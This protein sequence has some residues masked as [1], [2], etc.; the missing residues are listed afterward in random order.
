MAVY[1]RDHKLLFIQAPRTGSSAVGKVLRE[2]LGGEWLPRRP[3]LDHNGMKVMSHQH[4]TLK[5]LVDHD[6]LKVKEIRNLI[7][8]TT[9]RNPYDSVVSLYVK[10]AK[11]LPRQ[12]SNSSSWIYRTTNRRR[13][14]EFAQG[15]SFRRWVLWRYGER[16][17]RNLL[18][19]EAGS[20][21]GRYVRGTNALLRFESLQDDFS[22][23]LEM[24]GIKEEIQIPR[25][26]VT[27]KK[28]TNYQKYYDTIS[29]SIVYYRFRGDIQK[30]GYGF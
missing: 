27:T 7:I 14:I 30:Y 13:S 25:Y 16:A 9:V 2:Q 8:F 11:R 23:I 12:L 28:A 20:L 3:I 19:R 6:L 29:K 1:C 21:F 4:N 15:H 22:K 24:A 10:N 18:R 5:Q 26:N 17:W